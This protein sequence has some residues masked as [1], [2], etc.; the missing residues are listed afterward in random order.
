[1]ETILLRVVG[2]VAVSLVLLRLAVV[3]LA[4]PVA[5]GTGLYMLIRMIGKHGKERVRG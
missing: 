2:Y 1:M 5:W 4:I 3:G